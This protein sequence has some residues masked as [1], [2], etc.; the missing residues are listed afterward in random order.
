ML[1]ELVTR[2][3]RHEEAERLLTQ[4]LEMLTRQHGIEH[5]TTIGCMCALAASM[6]Q[7]GRS[8]MGEPMARRALTAATAVHGSMHPLVAACMVALAGKFICW[9]QSCE[10]TGVNRA[11]RGVSGGKAAESGAIGRDWL[12]CLAPA[13][14]HGRDSCSYAG[15]Y[16]VVAPGKGAQCRHCLERVEHGYQRETD[17]R[18]FP[19]SY[20][21]GGLHHLR[22][23]LVPAPRACSRSCTYLASGI[24]FC[25]IPVPPYFARYLLSCWCQTT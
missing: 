17:S 25:K 9:P 15:G 16:S 8:A 1:A 23:L 12:R 18:P 7:R 19:R 6:A 2:K 11:A 20:T 14:A 4:A 13:P 10:L 5:T 3:G 22:H 21:C 24:C